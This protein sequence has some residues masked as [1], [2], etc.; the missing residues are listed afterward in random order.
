LTISEAEIQRLKKA[1]EVLHDLASQMMAFAYNETWALYAA[2][3]L[4]YDPRQATWVNWL[5]KQNRHYR[6]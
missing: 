1:Q 4:G 6:S 2:K 3:G 5:I